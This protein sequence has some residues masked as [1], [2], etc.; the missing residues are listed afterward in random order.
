LNITIFVTGGITPELATQFQTVCGEIARVK[1]SRL[2]VMLASRG[3][4][5]V[6]GLAMYNSLR[7]LS[8]PVRMVNMGQVGSIAATIY[9]A[10]HQ[11]MAMPGANFFL[12]A[13][14]F[15]E[16]AKAGTIS[17][18]TAL[19]LAPFRDVLGWVQERLDRFFTS[20]EEIY[21]SIAE[22]EEIGLLN[23][24]TPP[25]PLAADELSIALNAHGK[26]APQMDLFSADLRARAKRGKAKG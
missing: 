20:T 23:D 11:R 2:T 21:L 10:G 5:V 1:C 3:G 15:V 4:D 17:P 19:I 13:A 9:T 18:N 6:S 12:H 8:C 16:G 24:A 26:E 14:W 25:G 7:L 22:A